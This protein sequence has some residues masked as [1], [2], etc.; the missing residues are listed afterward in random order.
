MEGLKAPSARK[1]LKDARW[2]LNQFLENSEIPVN[3]IVIKA[4]RGRPI[5]EFAEGIEA[6]PD[7]W[8]LLLMD[9]DH[10]IGDQPHSHYAKDDLPVKLKA[11][12]EWLENGV[13]ATDDQLHF[14][15]M[16][17]EA[18]FFADLECLD[19][20]FGK[21]FKQGDL[22][23]R[24]RVEDIPKGDLVSKLEAASRKSEKGKYEKGT[25]GPYLLALIDPK[26]VAKRAPDYGAR[27]L[28]TLKQKLNE[29]DQ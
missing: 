23:K 24:R 5:E 7:A 27:F 2:G 11:T 17:T 20:Y 21:G 19:R 29:R 9:A 25:H 14:M 10:V 4:C 28:K 15:V 18:W 1:S 26:K 13:Q 12:D 8:C 22:P 16:E 6:N 3:R